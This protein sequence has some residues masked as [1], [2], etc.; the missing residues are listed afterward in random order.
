[1]LLMIPIN[2]FVSVKVKKWQG[3]QMKLKDER[4]KMTNEVLNGVKVIKLYAWEEPMLR[5]IYDI[6]RKEV[7]LIKKANILKTFTDVIN[8][9]TPFTVAIT[10]FIIFL[11][12]S[13]ENKMTPQIA[14]VSL[15]LFANLRHPLML[16]GELI[17]LTV[18]T[19]ISNKRLKSFLVQEEINPEAVQRDL[20]PNCKF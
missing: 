4:Q 17:G 13:P 8:V 16:I 14:F 19:M 2:M 10:S 18:Q 15:S 9:T 6:R 3:M 11:I 1:M 7:A 5:V 20:N 12:I